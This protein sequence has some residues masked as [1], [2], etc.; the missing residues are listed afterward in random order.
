MSYQFIKSKQ[1]LKLPVVLLFL[2]VSS[3]QLMAQTNVVTGT[4]TDP[5]GE[6]LIGVNVVLKDNPTVGTITDMDGKFSLEAGNSKVFVFSYI[7]YAP[8]EVS[9]VGKNNIQVQLKEDSETLEEVVV[10]GYGTQKKGSL[11]GAISSVKSEELTRT[12]TPTTAG[13]L[14]GKTPGISARQADGRPG[15]SAAIQIRNMGTPLYVIDGIQCEEGQFNN[16]DVND[17]ES[18]TILKDASAAIY[19]LRAANGVVLVTTKSGKRGEKNQISANAYYGIQNFMRYPEVA[20]ASQFY[21]GRMQAD[22]NTYG[23]TARTME[24]LNLWRQGQGE[25]S[26]FDWQKFITNKNAPI[27]YGNVSATGGSERINYHFGVS[28]LDQKAMINGFNFARTNLQSNIE[29]N[30]TKSLKIGARLSG[31]I[32]ERHNVGVPGLDDYWQPYYAMFQNWPTQHAYANDN[33]NYVNATRNNA[34]GAAIFDRDITG[35]TDDIWKSAT[36]NVYAEWQSPIEGLKA[37]VAYNYWI[38]RNDQEQFEYTYKV[39]TYD[40]ANDS[41]NEQWGNQNPWRRRLKDEKVEQTFQA[42]LNYDHTFNQKHHVSGVLGIETFEKTRDW[43]QYNTLPTNNYIP[44]TN[45]IADMQSMETK[46]TTARRAGMVFRAA[47]DY[48]S[49]YFA[50]FSGRYDGSYLFQEGNRWGFFPAVSAGWRLSE[51]SF[52]SGV[53]EATKLSNLKIRA[54]WGQMGDDKLDVD[55]DGDGYLDDIV[56]PYSY[57]NGYTYGSGN[58]V[59]NGNAMTGVVY[60]GIPITTLSWIKSTLINIGVDYGFLDD[61]LSGTFEVFQRK[62]TGLPALRYDVLIPTEVGFSLAKENLNSDYHKGLELG[63]T[64]RDKV[65]DFSYSIGGNFTLA[66]KMNGDSYKPRFGSSWD[67]YRNSTEN[68]WINTNTWGYQVVG[69]FQSYEDI[70]NYH[71][72]NDGQGNTTMLPGDL[73]YKDQNGDGIINSLD[74]RPIGYQ[75]EQLPYISFGINTSFEWKGIDLKADFAGAA[76]QSYHMCWEVAYP[77]QGDGNSTAY[78]LTDSWHRAD[79]TDA[80]S[81]WIAG[82]FPATRYAG[83]NVS[84]NRYSD[85]WL[86]NTYYI[87]LRTLELGYTLPKSISSKFFVDRLRIYANAYNLFSIDNLSK[88]QLDPEIQSN[89]ALVTPNLRTF[90]FGFNLN[91]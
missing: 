70:Q 19:G 79:P 44:L 38:A 29:A 3:L 25:Y 55:E 64:W 53:K 84:F 46:M 86:H 82:K 22:L 50:E 58:A 88:Y 34:T 56:S 78:L 48:S 4:V 7:G 42:Q 6:P 40:K 71:V 10:V 80:N 65:R 16:I 18:I 30:I 81:E 13:A 61:R 23:S 62:R 47:Y 31:R 91:F 63:I 89:S 51:E 9:I 33:P 32:E 73:I 74:E 67:E 66:R 37:R 5:L 8:Q 45:G 36:A 69:R 24:E 54:S 2:L 26:S 1:L 15:A 57:L 68:R 90:S 72:D 59:L 35:Y 75:P 28:H 60:R 39:Y 14:V 83:A 12:T 17:V 41:Y 77:F 21:E 52:M 85:F 43:L 20:N 76:G 49:T 11:T 27:W 87:K